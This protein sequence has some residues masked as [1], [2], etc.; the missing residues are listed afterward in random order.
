MPAAEIIGV[1]IPIL[2]ILLGG[3]I[4][5]LPIAGLTARFALKPVVEAFASLRSRPGQDELVSMLEQRLALMEQQM[6][7]LETS[8]RRI[9]EDRSF[10]RS[11][12][13]GAQT[14]KQTAAAVPVFKPKA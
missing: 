7:G 4:V 14:P 10:D 11:L 13:A 3:L 2:A 9:E 6:H 8:L 1:F 5:L 12:H